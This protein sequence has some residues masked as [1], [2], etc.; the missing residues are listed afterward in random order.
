[1]L[2]TVY[3]VGF[4]LGLSMFILLAG[5][6]SAAVVL[7]RNRLWRTLG[8]GVLGFLA[9]LAMSVFIPSWM[10]ARQDAFGWLGLVFVVFA[11]CLFAIPM[12][13]AMR[14]AGGVRKCVRTTFGRRDE[15]LKASPRQ[16]DRS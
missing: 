16:P 15:L 6:S 9:F 5:L 7:Y 1:M 10:S 3:A 8:F 14:K 12:V 11:T 4:V 13:V 2:T